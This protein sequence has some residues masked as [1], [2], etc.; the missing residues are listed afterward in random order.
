[1]LVKKD[2]AKGKLGGK[3][4]LGTIKGIG[5][6]SQKKMPVAAKATQAASTGGRVLRKRN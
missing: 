4:V 3:G 6:G 2:E 5:M 1:M